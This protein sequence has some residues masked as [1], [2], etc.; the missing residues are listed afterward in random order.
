MASQIKTKLMKDKGGHVYLLVALHNTE[1]NVKELS[2]RLGLG[3]KVLLEVPEDLRSLFLA[4]TAHD[5][6]S[7]LVLPAS[8]EIIALI[9]AA[10]EA[11]LSI[12]VSPS[13]DSE[14]SS[15]S[16]TDVCEFL[17]SHCCCASLVDFGDKRKIGKEHPP[18]L[19]EV[20][21]SAPVVKAVKQAAVEAISAAAQSEADTAA[22]R[23][24][25]TTSGGPKPQAAKPRSVPAAAT[26]VNALTA[27]LMQK[28]LTLHDTAKEQTSEQQSEA[29][30]RVEADVRLE[31]TA[32]KNAAYASGHNA[33]RGAMRSLFD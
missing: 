13:S 25:G 17:R 14:S 3:K 19:A 15:K 18:D 2:A 31:L 22:A 23:K 1:F 30:H 28:V 33:A 29:R 27:A 8:K 12:Q 6:V 11:K 10:I 24:A 5:S 16:G 32:L 7:N 26:H 9:D 20:V 21:S 4:T